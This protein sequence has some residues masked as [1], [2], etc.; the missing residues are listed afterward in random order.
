M[1][2]GFTQLRALAHLALNDVSLQTLPNDIGKYVHTHKGFSQLIE[3]IPNW[4]PNQL[5]QPPLVLNCTALWAQT[6]YSLEA[7]RG[8]LNLL[9]GLL[10]LKKLCLQEK[11]NQYFNFHFNK[12]LNGN[13]FS[14]LSDILFTHWWVITTLMLC[15]ILPQL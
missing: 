2:D 7:I 15:P 11:K 10:N 3:L 9:S 14:I 8:A 1:P 13:V 6:N 4:T 5:V 12:K